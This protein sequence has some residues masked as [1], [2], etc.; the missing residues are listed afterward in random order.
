[1]VVGE[2]GDPINL[3][4]CPNY[5]EEFDQEDNEE[6]AKTNKRETQTTGEATHEQVKIPETPNLTDSNC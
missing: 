4:P 2:A 5:Q 6:E 1:M 3:S